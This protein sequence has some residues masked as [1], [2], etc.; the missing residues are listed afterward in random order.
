MSAPITIVVAPSGAHL[1]DTGSGVTW[2][3]EQTGRWP[4]FALEPGSDFGEG[5]SDCARCVAQWKGVR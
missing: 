1:S 2:C 4:T 5:K 3:G